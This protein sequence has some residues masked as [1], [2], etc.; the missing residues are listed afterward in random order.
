MIRGGF[1]LNCLFIKNA[2]ISEPYGFSDASELS[3]VDLSDDFII[4][5]L[6]II[7]LFH[8]IKVF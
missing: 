1:L 8:I 4:E 6:H 7:G 3:D 2:C 5:C